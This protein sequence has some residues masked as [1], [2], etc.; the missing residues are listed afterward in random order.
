MD[1]W[2]LS[3]DLLTVGSLHTGVLCLWLS[4][5]A[6]E[7]RGGAGVQGGGELGGAGGEGQVQGAVHQVESSLDQPED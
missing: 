1:M 2:M 3:V 5:E 7:G 4:G 6:V